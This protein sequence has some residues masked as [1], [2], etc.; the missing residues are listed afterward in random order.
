MISFEMLN[1]CAL[2]CINC[3]G[4]ALVRQETRLAHRTFKPGIVH[5]E[6]SPRWPGHWVTIARLVTTLLASHATH[7]V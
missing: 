7:L 1:W 5:P 6:V 2:A 3:T 4:E